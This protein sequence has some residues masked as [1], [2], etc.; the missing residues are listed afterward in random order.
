MKP[1]V[2]TSTSD[3][4]D[5]EIDPLPSVARVMR[6]VSEKESRGGWGDEWEKGGEEED[7]WEVKKPKKCLSF[8]L[9]SYD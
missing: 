5:E 2:K 6:V 7:E 8:G 9:D 4:R 3:M 1:L